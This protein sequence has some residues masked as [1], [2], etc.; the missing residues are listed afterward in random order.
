MKLT[1]LT[2]AVAA[3]T[4]STM[5]FAGPE[6]KLMEDNPM[7]K[8]ISS[9]VQFSKDLFEKE[10]LFAD[11]AHAT[12]T[13]MSKPVV[14]LPDYAATNL[15]GY[16]FVDQIQCVSNK[17]LKTYKDGSIS[18]TNSEANGI[19]AVKVTLK[20]NGGFASGVGL[21]LVPLGADG[22]ALI[23][24]TAGNTA[25]EIPTNSAILTGYCWAFENDPGTAI[26]MVAGVDT[27]ADEAIA[28]TALS[29]FQRGTDVVFCETGN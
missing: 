21:H 4:A 10:C 28:S 12:H 26:Y 2:A 15:D 5:A 3:F 23:V 14:D 9:V 13:I 22:K 19:A 20:S 6:V 27:L 1:K 7:I 11:V 18:S 17:A 29:S 8:E 25:T 24:D 16:K